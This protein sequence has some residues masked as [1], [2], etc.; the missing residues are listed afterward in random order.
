MSVFTRIYTPVHAACYAVAAA[1][2]AMLHKL[3]ATP[4]MRQL[5]L[6]SATARGYS[7][8]YAAG[9]RACVYYANTRMYSHALANTNAYPRIYTLLSASIRP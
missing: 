7:P 5:P 6:I 2:Y 8:R 3:T 1:C 4:R 9:T